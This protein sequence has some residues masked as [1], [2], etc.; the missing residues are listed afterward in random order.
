MCIRD[1]PPT[2][3]IGEVPR[4]GRVIEGAP[5]SLPELASVSPV[6]LGQDVPVGPIQGPSS[7]VESYIQ[8]NWNDDDDVIPVNGLTS[9]AQPDAGSDSKEHD[10]MATLGEHSTDLFP[11]TLPPKEVQ[12]VPPPP[13]ITPDDYPEY[14]NSEMSDSD[15]ESGPLMSIQSSREQNDDLVMMSQAPP[16]ANGGPLYTDDD[17]SFA[18]PLSSVESTPKKKTLIRQ[19]GSSLQRGISDDD[20][21]VVSPKPPIDSDYMNQ[22]AIDKA[23]RDTDYMNQDAI[24]QTLA[25][26]ED[27]NAT[28]VERQ[29]FTIRGSSPIKS[30]T[31]ELAKRDKDR[32][33]E[34]QEI[35]DEVLEGDII[36]VGTVPSPEEPI[37][38]PEV[39]RREYA[40]SLP[41]VSQQR[42]KRH[43][44]EDLDI[45]ENQGGS[46]SSHP[47][48]NT[49]SFDGNF[50][51]ERTAQTSVP[52]IVTST[53]SSMGQE[54]SEVMSRSSEDDLEIES[55]LEASGGSINQTFPR[56]ASTSSALHKP[57][58]PM[59]LE[60]I[61]STKL[62]S[63]SHAAE[64]DGAV[65]VSAPKP[66]GDH[67][68]VKRLCLVFDIHVQLT[69]HTS[70]GYS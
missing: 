42:V 24:D 69:S 6:D 30:R 68:E 67:F 2:Q 8:S 58:L 7:L 35:V 41:P 43:K 18:S 66:Y 52:S 39:I 20:I 27:V 60:P 25:D 15:E 4:E 46:S 14:S 19:S 36:P 57:P 13:P 17:D 63:H 28:N 11:P 38:Q 29:H 40:H 45:G 10:L 61:T 44:Y 62:R 26:E 34:N 3:R 1:R 65:S 49:V 9:L 21:M 50:R 31:L 48:S 47:R 33:Y 54:E 51:G 16:S 53:A 22:E 37:L 64:V 12:Q 56:T 55:T 59:H 5:T 23:N 32:D 70:P